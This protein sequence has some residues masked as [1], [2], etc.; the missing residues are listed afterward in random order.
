LLQA[1]EG[2]VVE[3]YRKK[4]VIHIER[5]T[6]DKK[7][8]ERLASVQRTNCCHK[9]GLRGRCKTGGSINLLGGE[10]R[11]RQ[12]KWLGVSTGGLTMSFLSLR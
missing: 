10:V 11:G 4:W 1:R 7:N 2:K 5:I 8:G 9:G 6:K 12:K 3:V